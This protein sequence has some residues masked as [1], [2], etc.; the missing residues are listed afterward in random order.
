MATSGTRIVQAVYRGD[1]LYQGPYAGNAPDLQ[2]GTADGFR[3]AWQTTAD[4]A[5]APVLSAN[6]KKWS[7]DHESFDYK[8]TPGTLMSSRPIQV[9]NPRIIDIAPTVLRYFGVPIPI[10]IDGQPLF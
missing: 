7:G 2:V 4:A 8:S 3:A 1:A 9:A 10:E 5:A 6:M